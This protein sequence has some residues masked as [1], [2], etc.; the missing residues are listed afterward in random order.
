MEAHHVKE[1]P[2]NHAALNF[3]RLTESD[4]GEREGGEIAKRAEG[5]DLSTQIL[6]FGDGESFIVG[7]DTRGALADVDQT[8]PVAIDERLEE[9]AAHQGKDRGV[10]ADSKRHRQYDSDGNPL[11]SH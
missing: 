4:H 3:A 10:G 11:R 8:F 7:T 9:H 6:D 2:A 5:L 1:R